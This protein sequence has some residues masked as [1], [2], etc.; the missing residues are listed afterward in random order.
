[1]KI[2]TQ[3]SRDTNAGE[4]F[5]GKPKKMTLER[6]WT[7]SGGPFAGKGWP[8]QNT[9]TDLEFARERGLRTAIASG[10]QSEGHLVEL[11][12]Q[13]FGMQWFSHGTLDIKLTGPVEVDDVVVARA[14]V[15][16]KMDDSKS[17]R[18]LFDVWVE[19]QRGV[20]VL[21]GNATGIK[22]Y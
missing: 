9:H 18:F 6:L 16:Q 2:M 7:F 1:M 17:V 10:T 11:L 4:Q 21:V 12:V 19:N 13:L 5:T 3:I 8:K 15:T 20:K 22:A 14:I